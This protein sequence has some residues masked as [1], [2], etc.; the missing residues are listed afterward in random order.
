MAPVRVVVVPHDPDWAR[1]FEEEA[2][3]VA[4]AMGDTVLAIHHI[5]S[6]SVAG[7]AAKPA[8]TFGRIP[9]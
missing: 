2:A 1:L 7:L 3:R 4:A 9:T 5:G 8:T 6:T